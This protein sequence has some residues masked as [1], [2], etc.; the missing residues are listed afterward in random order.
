MSRFLLLFFLTAAPLLE[1]G[2]KPICQLPPAES[3]LKVIPPPPAAKSFTDKSDL[4]AEEGLQAAAEK[5][6]SQEAIKHATRTAPLSVFLFSEVR[7]KDFTPKT[8]P[9]TAAFFDDLQ[10]A[11]G[12]VVAFLKDHYHRERPYKAHPHQVKAL[13]P[14]ATGY[15]FPS[16]HATVSWLDALILG[17]LDRAHREDYLGSAFQ[18]SIDRSVGGMHYPS[19]TAAGRTLAQAIFADLMAKP[20]FRAALEEMRK[21]EYGT[22]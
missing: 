14:I 16:G 19:D 20:Q 2:G 10:N 18:I 1:A 7:G 3:Y 15:S 17:E 11:A 21:A 12:G 4:G 22:R 13:I 9:K 5:Q 8:Y 6:A